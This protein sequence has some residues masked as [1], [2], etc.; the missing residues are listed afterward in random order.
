MTDTVWA[1]VLTAAGQTAIFTG[2]LLWNLSGLTSAS[3]SHERRI[4]T[5]EIF[6]DSAVRDI[7]NLQGREHERI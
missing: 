4:G 1:V 3:N 7:A 6:K 2:V 5:L